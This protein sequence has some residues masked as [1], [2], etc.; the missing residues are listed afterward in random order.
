MP[1]ESCHG[2]ERGTAADAKFIRLLHQPLPYE[3][4]M[5]AMALVHIKS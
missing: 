5:M 1:S 3:V 4:M 2:L